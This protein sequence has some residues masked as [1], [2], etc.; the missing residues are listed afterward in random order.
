MHKAGHLT[1]NR[2]SSSEKG[3]SNFTVCQEIR[4]KGSSQLEKKSVDGYSKGLG[5]GGVE[6]GA[7]SGEL[8]GEEWCPKVRE[9]STAALRS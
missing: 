6:G 1:E 9:K 8:N 5:L 3:P 2:T 7:R 4:G